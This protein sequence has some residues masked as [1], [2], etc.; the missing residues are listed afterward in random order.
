MPFFA[1]L[2]ET[3]KRGGTITLATNIKSYAKEALDTAHRPELGL[4][5][6]EFREISL[7]TEPH[8]QPRT[9]FE[10]KFLLRGKTCYNLVLR[11]CLD[12]GEKPR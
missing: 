12:I 4:S 1:Y 5:I 8:W 2:V 10:K 7:S 6:A 11:R 9:H 3:L